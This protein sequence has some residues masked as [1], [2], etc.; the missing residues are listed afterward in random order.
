MFDV[1]KYPSTVLRSI[2]DPITLFDEELTVLV[3]K[4]IDVMYRFDGVGIAAPQI[5]VPR[6]VVIIDPSGGEE[7]N[8]LQV[9]INPSVTWGSS[10]TETDREG[11]LSLPGMVLQVK[12]SDVVDVVYSDINGVQ[13]QMRCEGFK[14]RVVQHEIDH[15][16]GVLMFDRVGDLM[17]KLAMKN[18]G[19]GK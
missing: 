2:C 12:R 3:N 18:L 10:S 16:D 5:G 11:C 15:L 8:Q 1:V 4:M 14:A 19:K 6:R 9:L 7:S 13:H 17:R